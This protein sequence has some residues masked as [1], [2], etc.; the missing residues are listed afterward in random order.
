MAYLRHMLWLAGGGIYC[1][2]LSS[3]NLDLFRLNGF[4][5]QQELVPN[6]LGAKR[7]NASSLLP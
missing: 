6:I 7:F 1:F 4:I 3:H 2:Y 5:A